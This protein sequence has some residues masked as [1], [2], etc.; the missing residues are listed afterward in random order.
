VVDGGSTDR[1]ADVAEE[2]A[3]KV[4]VEP[5]PVGAARN[6]G[7]KHAKGN[8]LAFID[9]DTIACERWIEESLVRSTLTRMLPELLAQRFRM[10]DRN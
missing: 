6:I 8:I 5:S 7:A 1:T 3:Y 9:A 4:I 2:Y 10:R